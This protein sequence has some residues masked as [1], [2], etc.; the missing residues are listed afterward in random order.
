MKIL[1]YIILC[2]HII[3]AQ[4][5]VTGTE[6]VP[7]SVITSIEYELTKNNFT[8][9]EHTNRQR[10]FQEI[11]LQQSGIFNSS[12]QLGELIGARKMILVSIDN[13]N[14]CMKLVQVKSG[15]ITK[16]DCIIIKSNLL[17]SS[18]YLTRSIMGLKIND[19][20]LQVLEVEKHRTVTVENP[21]ITV[22]HKPMQGARRI[23]VP[24]NFCSGQGKLQNGHDCSMCSVTSRYSGPETK[25]LRMTGRWQYIR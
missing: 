25:G 16:T 17:I 18:R 3:M 21:V 9:I 2:V 14:L 22:I 4:I 12:I 24:C 6:N 13:K 11:A 5:A 15:T 1:L 19:K 8:V 20:E 7:K 10:L 23:F